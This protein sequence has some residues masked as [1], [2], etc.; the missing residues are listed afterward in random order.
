MPV[1]SVM[2]LSWAAEITAFSY[3]PPR[4]RGR[5]Q[6]LRERER[7]RVAVVV[8]SEEPSGCRWG[9]IFNTGGSP[10][11]CLRCIQVSFCKCSNFLSVHFAPCSFS[12]YPFNIP[13]FFFI[14]FGIDKEMH[15]EIVHTLQHV[16]QL[17]Y[18]ALIVQI[19]FFFFVLLSYQ[20]LSLVLLH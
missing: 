15:T 8:R 9:T 11:L 10:I 16:C 4:G 3:Y 1:Q 14:S 19:S 12:L 13:H 6:K 5:G 2:A 18:S 7:R 20:F 17:H